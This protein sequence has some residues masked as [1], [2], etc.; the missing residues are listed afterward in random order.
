MTID[1][2]RLL[3]EQ[4]TNEEEADRAREKAEDV[5]AQR[6]GEEEARKIRARERKLGEKES[7]ADNV[8]LMMEQ[9][10][11]IIQSCPITRLNVT[12]T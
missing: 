2:L 12:T 10:E 11:G 9:M 3:L 1:Q 6:R 7:L 5:E 4:K 8:Q